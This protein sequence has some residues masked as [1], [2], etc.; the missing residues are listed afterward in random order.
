MIGAVSV[1]HWDE[2]EWQRRAKG[3]MGA[4]WQLGDQPARAVSA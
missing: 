3:E 4:A 1:A 2:V